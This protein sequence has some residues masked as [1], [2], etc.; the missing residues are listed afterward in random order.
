MIQIM[1]LY[2]TNIYDISMIYIVNP[3]NPLGVYI[4][5]NIIEKCCN[6]FPNI[7]ILVDEA[8][9][10]FIYDKTSINLVNINKLLFFLGNIKFI[11]KFYFSCYFI[12]L[13]ISL[14]RLFQVE[15]STAFLA[16]SEKF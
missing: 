4:E 1:I 10:E 2:Y 8:Y 6:M 12:N 14:V 5:P 9:I 3:N 11:L 13:I 7:Y 16:S 15:D